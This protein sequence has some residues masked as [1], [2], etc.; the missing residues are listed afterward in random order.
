MISQGRLWVAELAADGR[1]RARQDGVVERAH[2]HRQQHAEHDQPRFLVG[3]GLV[4]SLGS[5]R[6]SIGDRA[7]LGWRV[8]AGSAVVRR[9][10][11]RVPCRAPAGIRLSQPPQGIGPMPGPHAAMHA[12]DDLDEGGT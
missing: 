5:V 11:A 6:A 1:Q 10:S 12:D 4:A 2:E 7:M 9:R 8:R 3:E